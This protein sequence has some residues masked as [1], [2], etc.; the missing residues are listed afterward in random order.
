MSDK[1]TADELVA[2]VKRVFTP[3][4]NDHRLAILVD[5][6]DAEAPD[7]PDWAARR[8]MAAEWAAALAPRASEAVA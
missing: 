2:L 6:P 8:Q 5:M 1:L 7:N 3:G 4:E